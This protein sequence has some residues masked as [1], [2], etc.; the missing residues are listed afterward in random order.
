MRRVDRLFENGLYRSRDG[1]ILGVFRGLAENLD[2][3]LFWLRVIAIIILS[4]SGIWPA[5]ILYFLAAVLMKP[6]P[7]I[8]LETP[9]EQEFYDSYTYSRKGAVH[10]LLRQFQNID[11]RIQ[12]MEHIVTERQ[13]DWE[14]K[15]NS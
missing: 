6:K 3:S 8:P 14:R 13:F 10:R 12:R 15:L 9:E 11:R 7:V 4:V 5:M 1:A 2:L